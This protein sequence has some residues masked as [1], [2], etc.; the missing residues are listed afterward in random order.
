[1]HITLPDGQ[2][3]S[4]DCKKLNGKRKQKYVFK[5]EMLKIY[6]EESNKKKPSKFCNMLGVSSEF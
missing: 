1:M 2:M 6:E 4:V 3:V 5:I